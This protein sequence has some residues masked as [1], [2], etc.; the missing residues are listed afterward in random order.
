MDNKGIAKN[1]SI[2]I[3]QMAEELRSNHIDIML[4]IKEITL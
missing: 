2:S 4:I 3:K 1:N